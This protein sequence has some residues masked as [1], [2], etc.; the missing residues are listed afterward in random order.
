MVIDNKLITNYLDNL[1]FEEEVSGNTRK[2][3][4]KLFPEV[5]KFNKNNYTNFIGSIIQK[6][7]FFLNLFIS[8]IQI[9]CTDNLDLQVGIC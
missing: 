1:I 7:K 8:L 5:Y 9:F 2:E 3:K 6:N 4:S